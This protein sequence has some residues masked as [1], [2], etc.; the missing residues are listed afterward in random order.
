MYDLAVS[1]IAATL[2]LSVAVAAPGGSPTDRLSSDDRADLEALIA[3]GEKQAVDRIT[4]RFD[5]LIDARLADVLRPKVADATP[6]AAG[7]D[8]GDASKQAG[9]DAT[10]PAV[11]AKRKPAKKEHDA[12]PDSAGEVDRA[13]IVSAAATWRFAQLMKD[14]PATDGEVRWKRFGA[15]PAFVEAVAFTHA[16][17]ADKPVAVIGVA[18][19]LLAV[20]DGGLAARFPEL[21]AAM[22]VVFDDPGLGMRVN[23]HAPKPPAVEYLWR[24]FTGNAAKMRYGLAAAPE[25][26]VHVVDVCASPDEIV[27]ALNKFGG[28]KRVGSLYH[29]VDYDFDVLDGDAKQ[30]NKAGWNLPNI[31]KHGGICAEQAYFATTVAKAI[32]IP[33]AY[34]VGSSAEANH[35]WVGFVQNGG[36]KVWWDVDGRYDSYRGVAGTVRDPQTGRSISDAVLPMLVQWGLEPRDERVM[37]CALRAVDERLA[38]RAGKGEEAG[39]REALLDARA[40]VLREALRACP[41]D[42]RSWSRVRELGATGA[43]DAAEMA[44][45]YD[46]ITSLCGAAYPEMVLEVLSPMVAAVKD[47]EKQHGY[48]IALANGLAKRGDLAGQALMRDAQLWEKQGEPEKAGQQ[49]EAILRAYPDGGPYVITALERAGKILRDKRDGK[50]L[51]ALYESTFNRIK[52]PEEMTKILGRQST[53]CRVGKA[54]VRALNDAGRQQEAAA[55]DAKIEKFLTNAAR[56]AG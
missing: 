42:A 32:G 36:G 37:A 56:N 10:K 41:T 5:A 13:A 51:V 30:V 54:Y 2:V 11:A 52:P 45:W 25:L 14:V 15:A 6:D 55:L 26:L 48:W 49:Y 23:E 9:K 20:D 29:E 21:A 53:W 33:A 8:G 35:A 24:Y 47:N 22:C 19:K 16:T 28:V 31:L 50:R 44:A 17:K 3:R 43:F 34:T 40:T 18:D 39:R 4:A 7:A 46:D 1:T 27:W 38:E 12:K